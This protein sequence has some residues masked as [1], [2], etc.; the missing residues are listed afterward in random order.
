MLM[1]RT[2]RWG[3]PKFT[4]PSKAAAVIRAS[5]QINKNAAQSLLKA[6]KVTKSTKAGPIR[7]KHGWKCPG[8]DKV[9]K[10]AD[11]VKKHQRDKRHY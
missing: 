3:R 1:F 5:E 9:K 8:C 2:A 7:V 10:H 6:A 11:E 4:L